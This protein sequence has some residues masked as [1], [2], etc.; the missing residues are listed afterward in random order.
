MGE[1]FKHAI[2]RKPGPDCAQGLTTGSLG[3]ADYPKLLQQHTDY[4]NVLRSIGLEVIVLEALPGYPDAYFV[5]DA[6]VITPDVAVITNPGAPSRQGEE[7]A[8]GPLLARYRETARIQAPGTVEGGDVLMVGDHFFVGISERT[9]EEG[10]RQLGHILEMYGHSWQPVAVADGL[11][12]KSSVNVVGEDTLLLT[13]EY[14]GRAEFQGFNQIVLDPAEEY[15]SNT[16]WIDDHLLMPA[17]FPRT[18][19]RLV[20]LGLDIVELDVGEIRKMDGGLTCMSL[21]F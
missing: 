8:L 13:E 4:I 11:H 15:A 19:S 2:V 9:N 10:A 6:A 5:E 17:G 16:L 18:K 14:A 21:R 1:Q 12:L 3:S 7:R 20:E